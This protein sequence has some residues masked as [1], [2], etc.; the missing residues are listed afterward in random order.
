M[1]SL[2][3]LLQTDTLAATGYSPLRRPIP[4]TPDL[5]IIAPIVGITLTC[6]R[7]G[8]LPSG[9][10]YLV[11]LHH[12]FQALLTGKHTCVS[13]GAI[14]AEALAKLSFRAASG[15]TILDSNRN[16]FLQPS[17]YKVP[18]STTTPKFKF[19]NAVFKFHTSDHQPSYQSSFPRDLTFLPWGRLKQGYLRQRLLS[20]CTKCNV[21]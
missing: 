13:V 10:C 21:L 18:T 4:I 20:D 9:F 12:I 17:Q 3:C 15:P 7:K 8:K 1:S 6:L 11:P 16:L 2:P 14:W 19:I 5:V